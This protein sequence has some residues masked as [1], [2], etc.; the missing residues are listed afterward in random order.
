MIPLTVLSHPASSPPLPTSPNPNPIP[1]HLSCRC[2][3]HTAASSDPNAES[4]R[5]GRFRFQDEG[6]GFRSSRKRRWWSDDPS[7]GLDEKFEYDAFEDDDEDEDL[8]DKIW[9]F[10]VFRSYGYLLPVIIASTLLATGPKAFLMALALPLAQS[11]LSLAIE[12][13]WCKATEPPRRART[14]PMTKRKPFVR[15]S[16]DFRKQEKDGSSSESNGRPGYQSWMS[17]EEG[18]SDRSDSRTYNFGGWDDLDMQRGSTSRQA[19]TAEPEKKSKLSKKGRYKD[20]PLLFRLLI[21]VFPFLGSWTRI[22]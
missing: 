20:V 12:K 18:A 22:L 10:K 11:A 19:P 13:V 6:G 8:W 3:R 4:I 5:S 7:D 17:A 14:S 2:S 21:A 9:I 16:T 1:R 15:S